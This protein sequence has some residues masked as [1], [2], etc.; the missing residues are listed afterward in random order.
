M[1]LRNPCGCFYDRRGFFFWIKDSGIFFK[2]IYKNT[3]IAE[4]ISTINFSGICDNNNNESKTRIA[5]M[6][7]HTQ[8]GPFGRPSKN[9]ERDR[10]KR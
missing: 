5:L 3:V 10:C 1:E 2:K 4:K 7:L 6:K 9:Q 8:G